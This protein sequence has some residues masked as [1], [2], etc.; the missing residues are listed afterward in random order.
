MILVPENSFHDRD[1]LVTD[2]GVIFEVTD[3]LQEADRVLAFPRYI[4][5]DVIPVRMW[6][7][8][9]RMLG[10]EYSR[11]DLRV[12]TTSEIC[13]TFDK[14]YRAYPQ[15]APRGSD[16]FDVASVP[17]ESIVEHVMPQRSLSRILA[18]PTHDPLQAAACKFADACIGLG[19]PE[20]HLGVTNSLMFDGH[21][22][23]FSDIDFVVYG[24]RHY[25][26]LIDSLRSGYCQASI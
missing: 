3:Y 4:P 20:D 26:A 23:G 15:F 22:V 7:H 6:G 16:Q 1:F 18:L 14:F 10:R 25:Q 19:I 9:W 17:H 2:A 8:T 13:E 24:A 5:F 11:F 12:T 21:T